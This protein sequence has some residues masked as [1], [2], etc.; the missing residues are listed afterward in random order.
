MNST[1]ARLLCFAVTVG[2]SPARPAKEP[3]EARLL[4]SF[5]NLTS[6][7]YSSYVPAP[8]TA[9]HDVHAVIKQVWLLLLLLLLARASLGAR[10]ALAAATAA[11]SAVALPP[12]LWRPQLRRL[13]GLAALLF[14]FTAIGADGVPPV[15]QPRSVP[16]GIEGLP[17]VSPAAG[18]YRYVILHLWLITVTRRSIALAVSAASLTFVALQSASLCLTTTPPEELAGAL[19]TLLAPAGLLGSPVADIGL[20][21]LLSLRFMALVFDEARNLALGLAAR[22]V[23]W[24]QLGPGGSLQI[25]MRLI[26]RLF[27]NLMLRSESIAVAMTARGF[28]GPAAHVVHP[29]GDRPSSPLANA[30]ALALLAGVAA[31]IWSFS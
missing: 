25:A 22:G 5:L 3:L 12:G 8:R 23:A 4:M 2:T 6:V 19:R 20:T 11:L 1:R 27:A 9:L 17:G 31:C 30:A 18:G 21:L 15:L 29:M 13:G 24:S 7:P 26:A 28:A 14:V 16:P 10:F